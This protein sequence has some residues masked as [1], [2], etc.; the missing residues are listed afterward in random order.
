MVAES[1]LHAA[2]YIS[3]WHFNEKKKKLSSTWIIFDKCNQISLYIIQYYSLFQVHPRK[4]YVL[5]KWDSICLV[6]NLAHS[7]HLAQVDFFANFLCQARR[8]G[9]A[10]LGWWQWH[11]KETSLGPQPRLVK[12]GESRWAGSLPAGKAAHSRPVRW[13]LG[14]TGRP[15][16]RLGARP[17]ADRGNWFKG[18]SPWFLAEGCYQFNWPGWKSERNV[19]RFSKPVLRHQIYF[20]K[21]LKEFF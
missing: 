14:H 15:P 1:L 2:K 18:P 12:E 9:A 7:R 3:N 4:R 6:L 5:I 20:F 13:Q 16:A 11:G 10:C 21:G 17:G 19:V 8:E